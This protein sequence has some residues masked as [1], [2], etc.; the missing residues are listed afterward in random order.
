MF[1]VKQEGGVILPSRENT[2][3]RPM[4]VKTRTDVGIAP[5]SFPYIPSINTDT[6][7]VSLGTYRCFVCTPV[8]LFHWMLTFLCSAQRPHA[9]AS[10]SVSPRR[11]IW[12]I[13]VIKGMNEVQRTPKCMMLN[14]LY[15]LNVDFKCHFGNC[16]LNTSSL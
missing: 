5:L 11:G 9:S 8:P 15:A 12:H 10:F 3:N 7:V 1:C 13:I 6:L 4:T 14:L 2:L 16:S